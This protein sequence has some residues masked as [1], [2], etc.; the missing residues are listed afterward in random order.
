MSDFVFREGASEVAGSSRT[1]DPRTSILV[2]GFCNA[3][4]ELEVQTAL[5]TGCPHIHGVS[6]WSLAPRLQV[7]VRCGCMADPGILFDKIVQAS[8]C[9]LHEVWSA[10]AQNC[11]GG[12]SHEY[13]SV[14]AP[15]R[16][17]HVKA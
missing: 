10:H 15:L 2:L 1:K 6:G 12:S 17:L 7:Y 3:M 13:R 11:C 4:G 8:M 9:N 5:P 16:L 14:C